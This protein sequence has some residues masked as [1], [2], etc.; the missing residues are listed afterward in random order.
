[1]RAKKLRLV[2]E[3][4]QR[5]SGFIAVRS[6][7]YCFSHRPFFLYLIGSSLLA[8]VAALLALLS[9]TRQLLRQRESGELPFSQ[10]IFSFVAAYPL[11]SSG[12]FLA[13]FY[14]VLHN[15]PDMRCRAFPRTVTLCGH[16]VIDKA[17]PKPTPLCSSCV[18][19]LPSSTIYGMYVFVCLLQKSH[20]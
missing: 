16:G 17:P 14:T 13:P 11:F 10:A 2:I 7:V 6:Y 9:R 5:R 12:L 15:K 4:R 8:C 18:A 1:M 3:S 19:R 20:F